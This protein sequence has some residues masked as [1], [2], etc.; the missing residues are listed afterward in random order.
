MKKKIIQFSNLLEI[1]KKFSNQKIVLCHG[2][3]DVLHFGHIKHLQAA[4]EIGD[5]L[6]VSISSDKFVNKGPGRPFFKLSKRL[7][8]IAA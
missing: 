2:V 1:R 6:I 3:F 8:T 4:R 7:E 5:L